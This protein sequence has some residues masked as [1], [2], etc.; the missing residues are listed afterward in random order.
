MIQVTELNYAQLCFKGPQLKI[1]QCNIVYVVPWPSGIRCKMRWKKF[2][3][4]KMWV[5]LPPVPI[6]FYREIV[7]F[8]LVKLT[9][10]HDTYV[11]YTAFY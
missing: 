8:A 9:L 3:C 4:S 6:Y 11:F 5:R 10:A 1:L 2:A 7:F